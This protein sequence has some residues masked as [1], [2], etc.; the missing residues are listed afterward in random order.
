MSGFGWTTNQSRIA[1]YREQAQQATVLEMNQMV[2][3]QVSR[4]QKLPNY[5]ASHPDNPI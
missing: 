4:V 3:I 1:E 2:T 5:P